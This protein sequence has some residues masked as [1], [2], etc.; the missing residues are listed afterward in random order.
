MSLLPLR[1]PGVTGDPCTHCAFFVPQ[2][3]TDVSV[4]AAEPSPAPIL[5]SAPGE[6]Q[7]AHGSRFP[8]PL[9]LLQPGE[10][11]ARLQRAFGRRN[12]AAPRG[13]RA[14]RTPSAHPQG[15][16]SAPQRDGLPVSGGCRPLRTHPPAPLR[17]LSRYLLLLREGG[18]LWGS[19]CTANPCVGEK[20]A[21]GG[22]RGEGEGRLPRGALRFAGGET[23]AR[24][25]LQTPHSPDCGAPRR[26]LRRLLCLPRGWRENKAGR[27]SAER[28]LICGGTGDWGGGG[29]GAMLGAFHCRPPVPSASCTSRCGFALR[30]LSRRRF[31]GKKRQSRGIREAVAV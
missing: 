28:C 14:A 19:H 13:G 9:L 22:G 2:P 3:R 29:G 27:S 8:H 26:G 1:W 18:A 21:N 10:P 25:A 24:S 5:H 4:L 12:G 23:E 15:P 6:H 31:W 17:G 11:A 7:G 20:V 16:R 30:C